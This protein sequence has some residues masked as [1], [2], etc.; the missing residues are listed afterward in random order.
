MITSNS[1]L[2]GAASVPVVV[3][4]LLTGVAH[5]DLR[6]P[7]RAPAPAVEPVPPAQPPS[8]DP[9]AALAASRASAEPAVAYDEPG[10]GALWA[11][12]AT[13]KAKFDA[14]GAI[15]IPRQG[16]SAPRNAPH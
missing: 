9:H 6:H 8:F 7:V 5:A 11:V 15:W 4:L 2:A 14:A 13:W 1:L 3:A 10:D 16:P 12:G